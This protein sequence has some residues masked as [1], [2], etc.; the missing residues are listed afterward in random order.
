MV[1]PKLDG[2]SLLKD[3]KLGTLEKISL[4]GGS[5]VAGFII[6]SSSQLQWEQIIGIDLNSFVRDYMVAILPIVVTGTDYLANKVKD[7][8]SK[9]FSKK[10]LKALGASLIGSVA[11]YASGEFIADLY[12]FSPLDIF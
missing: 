5:A 10:S 9:L 11:G 8:S 7:N 3:S 6:G 2:D 12:T 1:T 4:I